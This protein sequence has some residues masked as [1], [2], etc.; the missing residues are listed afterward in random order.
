LAPAANSSTLPFAVDSKGAFVPSGYEGDYPSVVMPADTTCGGNRS[1]TTA[2]GACHTVNY[3][4]TPDAGIGKGWAGVVWQYP[5]NNWGTATGYL[6]P[7]GA[8]TVSF[9]ARGATGT[10]SVSFNVGGIGYGGIP[11]ATNPCEDTVT[12]SLAKSTLSTTWTHYNIPIPD[13]T[14]SGGVLNGFSWVA[15]AADQ[16]PTAT[17]ITFYVDDIEWQ[18]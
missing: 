6:I 11:S 4:T 13:A 2:L 15:G 18:E 3:N 9:W 1:S 7:P 10:E 17:E 8:T 14:Y 16:P 12:G 5:A